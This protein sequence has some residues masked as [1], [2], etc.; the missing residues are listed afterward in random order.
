MFLGQ[1]HQRFVL[2]CF[3]K[4]RNSLVHIFCVIIQLF[5]FMT[6]KFQ[7]VLLDNNIYEI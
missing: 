4:Y 1:R 5:D 6:Q 2:V 3:N 7:Y